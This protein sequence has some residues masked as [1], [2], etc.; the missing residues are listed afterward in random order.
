M[1]T[2]V[3]L[4]ARVNGMNPPLLLNER[5]NSILTQL[6]AYLNGGAHTVG[7]ATFNSTE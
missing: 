6:E 1:S 2:S 3:R 7:H 4:M 5:N